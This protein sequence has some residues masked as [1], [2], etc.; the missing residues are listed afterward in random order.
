MNART[1]D[2]V[3]AAVPAV[4]RLAQ[5]RSPIEPLAHGT[6]LSSSSPLTPATPRGRPASPPLPLLTPTLAAWAS[7]LSTASSPSW[8]VDR[9]SGVLLASASRHLAADAAEGAVL[10]NDA[11]TLVCR[12]Q[13][14]TARLA[15]AVRRLSAPFSPLHLDGSTR[16]TMAV[17]DA[18]GRP[19]PVT[20][21]RIEL[22]G[23]ADGEVQ[24]R[25]PACVLVQL[26]CRADERAIDEHMLRKV[27]GLTTAEARVAAQIVRGLPPKR[28][29]VRLGIAV[30]TVRSQLKAVFAKTGTSRQ[31]ELVLVLAGL[32][33]AG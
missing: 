6:P 30:H 2:G 16:D 23:V 9:Q 31:A 3:T 13:M 19:I 32:A 5:A 24:E 14:D 7:L 20:L 18:K 11:G 12:D 15:V 8:I 28:I 1:N 21:C 26:L 4:A 27:F 10:W 22:D 17:A 29:A 33:R 25:G